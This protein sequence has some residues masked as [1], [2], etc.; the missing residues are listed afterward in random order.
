MSQTLW[1]G[2]WRGQSPDGLLH[3]P[4]RDTVRPTGAILR[5]KFPSRKTGRMVT[6]EGLLEWRALYLFEASPA[7]LSYTEQPETT[8]YPYGPR[9]RR[10]TP[11]FELALRGGSTV[12]I[13]VKPKVN[14][15]RPEIRDKLSAVADFLHRQGR[16]F[17]ILTDEKICIEPRFANL[18]WVYHRARRTPPSPEQALMA[19]KKLEK[20]FPISIS[21]AVARLA[22]MG[23]E[24]YSLLMA[25]GLT[26][27]LSSPL[28]SDTHLYANLENSHEWF[29]IS[30]G[31][32]F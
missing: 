7:V 31:L 13:E 16:R 19:V 4:A 9:L 17:H 3:Q 29:R 32:G 28:T 6:F 1:R 30:D 24:P 23:L 12:L 11:D 21:D 20:A 5:G 22:P 14:A 18:Q 10:Y 15:I 26:C 8:R 27:D 25:G 2:T